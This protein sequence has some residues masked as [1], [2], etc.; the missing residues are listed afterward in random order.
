MGKK[1]G[2][3]WDERRTPAENARAKLPSLVEE[4]F[5]EGRKLEPA[6]N[7]G[8]MHRFRLR[9]K[10]FRYT[11]EL[12]RACYGPVFERRLDRLR[13]IQQHLGEMNDCETAL[14]L[15]RATELLTS[16]QRAKAERFLR[17]KAAEHQRGFL[18]YWREIFDAPGEEQS[19]V[20]YLARNARDAG[21]RSRR[22]R[23]KP[24]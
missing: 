7:A 24:R 20:A 11:L 10:R 16:A 14:D 5:A 13:E 2:I 15:L 3:R 1:S 6:T 22:R 23:A 21:G 18:Q 9:T 8:E 4:Y 12:F 19:W 17:A